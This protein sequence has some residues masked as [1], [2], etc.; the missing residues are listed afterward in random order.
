MNQTYLFYFFQFLK[1]ILLL[2]F[3]FSFTRFYGY[4]TG[5]G[6]QLSLLGSFGFSVFGMIVT[7]MLYAIPTLLA[8][9]VYKFFATKR[10][11]AAVLAYV[12]FAAYHFFVLRH[13]SPEF[14]GLTEQ[15]PSLFW[16]LFLAIIALAEFFMWRKEKKQNNQ[17]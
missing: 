4:P 3:V 5:D 11:I 10:V 17:N 8:P 15:Y 2:S 12:I 7:T 14:E 6:G 9:F 16:V 13:I 1:A